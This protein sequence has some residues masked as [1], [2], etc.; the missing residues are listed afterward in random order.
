MCDA[1]GVNIVEGPDELLCNFANF[2]LLQRLVILDDI[3]ELA[4]S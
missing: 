4:L 2:C 3:E 1:V